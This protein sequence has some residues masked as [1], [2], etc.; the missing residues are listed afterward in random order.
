MEVPDF[1][2]FVDASLIRAVNTDVVEAVIKPMISS[3]IS[4]VR[5]HN[6][7]AP[8]KNPDKYPGEKK[9][10]RPVNLEMTGEMMRNFGASSSK[11]KSIAIGILPNVDK[12][13]RD[14]ARGNNYG[15]ENG[16]SARRFFP[17]EGETWK[18]SVLLALREVFAERMKRLLLVAGLSRSKGGK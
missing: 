1:T 5:G 12:G 15:T 6:R 11:N 7:F 13:I 4:P 14:R 2:G 18:V 17:G 8:Y 10:K 3:G 9:N 16:L